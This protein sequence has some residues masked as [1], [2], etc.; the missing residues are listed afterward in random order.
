MSAFQAVYGHLLP[1]LLYHGDTF[2]INSTFDQQLK[3]R[4][5]EFYGYEGAFTGKRVML[6]TYVAYL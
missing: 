4:D 2:T 3:E 1:P 5:E 6:A